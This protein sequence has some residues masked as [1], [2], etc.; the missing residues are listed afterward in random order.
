MA[1][2]IP[3]QYTRLDINLAAEVTQELPESKCQLPLYFPMD[4]TSKNKTFT[5]R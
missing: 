3:D 5:L 2:F 1:S 4:M